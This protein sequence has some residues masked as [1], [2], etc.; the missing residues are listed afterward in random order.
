VSAPIDISALRAD[1]QLVERIAAGEH[2][3]A[4]EVEQM[5]VAWAS[6]VRP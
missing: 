4:D 2:A 1:D 6:G 5:L 3:P